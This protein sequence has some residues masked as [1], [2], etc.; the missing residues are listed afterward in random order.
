[1][2]FPKNAEEMWAQGYQ[3]AGHGECAGC[4]DQ[5]EWWRT[6]QGRHIPMNRMCESTSP[7]IAH[8]ATCPESGQFRTPQQQK[9][10]PAPDAR[11]AAPQVPPQMA[12]KKA[13]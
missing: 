2:P 10:V 9:Q 7:A 5:I 3:F 6:P 8:W 11:L 4:H 12:M 13:S 1:M